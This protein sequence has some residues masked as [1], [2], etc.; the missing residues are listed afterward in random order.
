[1]LSFIEYYQIGKSEG[2]LTFFGIKL[3]NKIKKLSLGVIL[4]VFSFQVFA[5]EYVRVTVAEITSSD[6]KKIM[7][8]AKKT[9]RIVEKFIGRNLDIMISIDSPKKIIFS[10][11]PPSLDLLM[12]NTETINS[13]PEFIK[14]QAYIKDNKLW[15]NPRTSTYLLTSDNTVIK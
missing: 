15:K 1:M 6:R 5:A 7:R 8:A 12:K 2:S 4:C 11:R 14:L 3:M 10:S 9:E 13:D